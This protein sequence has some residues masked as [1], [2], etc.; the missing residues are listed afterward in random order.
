MSFLYEGKKWS[1]QTILLVIF[2][3]IKTDI[4]KKT[5]VHRIFMQCTLPFDK[6][7]WM[8]TTYLL[9]KRHTGVPVGNECYVNG[10]NRKL[11]RVSAQLFP[12]LY[13]KYLQFCHE[14]QQKRKSTEIQGSQFVFSKALRLQTWDIFV[15]ANIWIPW[16]WYKNYFASVILKFQTTFEWFQFMLRQIIDG[17]ESTMAA[18]Y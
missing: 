4:S 2:E 13:K 7:F 3:I 11:W 8:K 16:T 17:L 5:K 15:L 10:L 1:K 14:R 12:N 9:S 6:G 18:R